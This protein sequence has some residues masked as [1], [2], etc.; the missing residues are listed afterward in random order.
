MH[1]VIQRERF[2]FKIILL[3]SVLIFLDRR[4]PK[5]IFDVSVLCSDG[6]T[7]R[8]WHVACFDI[9]ILKPLN[10]K[11]P[12]FSPVLTWKLGSLEQ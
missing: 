12:Q 5:Y 6:S 10:K 11:Y 9:K 8:F 3:R 4:F 2:C 1:V 7:E